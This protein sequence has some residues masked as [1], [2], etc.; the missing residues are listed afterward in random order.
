MVADGDDELVVL[1]D[2]V[3]NRLVETDFEDACGSFEFGMDARR[4]GQSCL[5]FGLTDLTSRGVELFDDLAAEVIEHRGGGE[6]L[7]GVVQGE[8]AKRPVCAAHAGEG[9]PDGVLGPF[10]VLRS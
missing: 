4:I 5:D 3:R 6:E 2:V 7:I 9:L 8:I 10:G 1:A